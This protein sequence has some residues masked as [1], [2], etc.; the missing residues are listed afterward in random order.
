MSSDQRINAISVGVT[1]GIGSGKTE[2]CK[3]LGSMGAKVLFADEIAKHLMNTHIGIKKKIQKIFGDKIY[4]NDGMLDRREMARMVFHDDNLKETLNSIVHPY[5]I[6]VIKDEIK[7]SK[8]KKI[9]RLIVIEAA[10]IFETCTE[11]MFD[12]TIVV[13]SD[14]EERIKRVMQRDDVNRS[15]VLHRIKAQMPVNEKIKR[16]D[17]VFHNSSNVK[18]LEL[19]CRFFFN[20]MMRL[21][22]N[23]IHEA[24]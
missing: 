7:V 10:L 21:V 1:G 4:T 19:T 11:G 17:F 24:H 9:H 2:V 3:I 15:E 13:D 6:Q 12:Y 23:S 22:S 20:L 5:V 14:A 8:Q 18:A 16:A